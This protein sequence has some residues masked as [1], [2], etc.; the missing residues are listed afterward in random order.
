MS[1]HNIPCIFN[2]KLSIQTIWRM[3]SFFL[4][5]L[6]F[7]TFRFLTYCLLPWLRF[8]VRLLTAAFAISWIFFVFSLLWLLFGGA[9]IANDK[10]CKNK[11][12]EFVSSAK[13]WKLLNNRFVNIELISFEFLLVSMWQIFH[14]LTRTSMNFRFYYF[15]YRI[16]W[17]QFQSSELLFFFSSLFKRV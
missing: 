17:S 8:Y 1:Y 7:A 16:N 6:A 9:G 10:N 13:F 14:L 2:M 5:L 11:K 15:A 12:R 3:S 4:A